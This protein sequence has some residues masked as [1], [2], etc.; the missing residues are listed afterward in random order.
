M[1]SMPGRAGPGTSLWHPPHSPALRSMVEFEGFFSP[2]P[3]CWAFRSSRDALLNFWDCETG[4]PHCSSCVLGACPQSLV[5]V[6]RSSYHDVVKV[7]EISRHM[8]LGEIQL[9]IINGAKVVFLRRRPQ[10]KAPRGTSSNYTCLMCSRHLQ[11][12]N[13]FCS[14]Q[15]KLDTQ[16]P[17]LEHPSTPLRWNTV[18]AKATSGQSQMGPGTPPGYADAPMLPSF[19]RCPGLSTASS[20]HRR[21]GPPLRAHYA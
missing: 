16:A 20:N 17:N 14:L 12:N 11:D 5:Q 7:A 18:P 9:Y 21:K 15:C 1:P 3:S 19:E 8:D 6:R 13:M 10:P 2:C 4:Q